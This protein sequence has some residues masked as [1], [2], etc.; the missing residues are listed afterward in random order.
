MIAQLRT[1]PFNRSPQPIKRHA[2]LVQNPASFA[3]RDGMYMRPLRVTRL[4]HIILN[5]MNSSVQRLSSATHPSLLSLPNELLLEI[6]RQMCVYKPLTVAWNGNISNMPRQSLR[7]L[8]Q[9]NKV[10]V[11]H[12][13]VY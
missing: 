5:N 12:E 11:Q 2:S 9:V 10:S 7:A 6:M 13:C 1:I 8:S 3:T 4:P